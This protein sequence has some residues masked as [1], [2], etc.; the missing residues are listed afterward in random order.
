MVDL[1]PGLQYVFLYFALAYSQKKRIL[2]PEDRSSK[3]H[4]VI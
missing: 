2:I 4:A 1:D 3:K